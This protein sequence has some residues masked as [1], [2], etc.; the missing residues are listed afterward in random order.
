MQGTY[1]V[2]Q[3]TKNASNIQDKIHSKLVI[4]YNIK[5]I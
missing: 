4:S 2:T 5:Q 1:K 3:W